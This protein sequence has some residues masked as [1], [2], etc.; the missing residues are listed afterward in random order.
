MPCSRL[1]LGCGSDYREGY[2]NVDRVT[3][4]ADVIVEL[5]SPPYPFAD[6]S[7][8]E[9]LLCHVLEHVHDVRAVLDEIWRLMRPQGQLLIHVPHFSHFQALTHPEH[10]H[11]FHYN[12]LAMFT[13]E[14]REHYTDRQWRIELAQLHFRWRLLERLFNRH[15]HLYTTTFL[16]YLFPAY[17]IEFV[18]RPVK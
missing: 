6:N 18:L 15:K 14:G 4:K 8:D 16:A 13:P 10:R 7:M 3:G 11:A 2:V 17:E 9:V 1:N 12:S 5:D